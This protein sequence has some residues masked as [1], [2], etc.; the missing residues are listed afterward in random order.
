MNTHWS[1]LACG[2]I[3]LAMQIPVCAYGD[4]K[5]AKPVSED[6]AYSFAGLYFTELGASMHRA[7]DQE[8]KRPF[9]GLYYRTLFAL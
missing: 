1:L 3:L 2:S 8:A 4:E 6:V 5:M 7:K 9:A